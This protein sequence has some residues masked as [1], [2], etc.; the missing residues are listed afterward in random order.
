MINSTVNSVQH[1]YYNFETTN[2]SFIEM[3]NYLKNTGRERNKF[4]LAL[5]D[6]DLLGV[7]PRDPNL[8]RT[9]KAKVIREVIVNYWYF[10]REVVRIPVPGNA[11]GIRYGLHRGNLAANFLFTFNYN[12]FLELPRQHGKTTVALIR[13]L[14]LYNFGATFTEMMFINKK[15]EDTKRA[16][17]DV[18]KYRD[19]LPEYLQFKEVRERDGSIARTKNN[20]T[21][22]ENPVNHNKIRT[23]PG[24]RTK[25]LAN[26][27]GRGCT[28]AVQYYD[29]FGWILYNKEIYQAAV[30]AFSTASKNA[31]RNKS[32]FGILIT[33]TPGDMTTNEG[34]F[35]KE[36]RDNATPWDESFYD[37]DFAQLEEIRM[38]NSSSTFFHV[39]YSYTQLGSGD[40]YFKDMVKQM[41]KDWNAIRR[42]VLLEW[43]TAN[44]NC[45]FDKDALEIIKGLCKTPI[46]TM[47]LGPMKQ[48]QFLVYKDIDLR[49]PPII[50][51]D[52][53]GGYQ[54]DSSTIT[55][56]DSRTTEVN[57]TFNCNY[58]TPNDL[59]R[60]IYEL[61]TAYMP[62]AIVNI[63]QNGGFGASVIGVLKKTSIRKNLYYEWK[64][65]VL[66]ERYAGDN[67][68]LVK[69]KQTV[70]VYG[71]N[72]NHNV[73][74]QLIDLLFERVELHKDKFNAAILHQEM[75]QMEVKSNG[76][77]EHSSNSHDDQVF[78]YLMALY[79]WYYGV[80]LRERYNIIK[81]NLT[82]DEDLE[83]EYLSLEDQFAMVVDLESIQVQPEEDTLHIQETIDTISSNKSMSYDEWLQSEKRKDD[84]AMIRIATDPRTKD[85]FIK[86]YGLD[87]KE[88][89]I[90]YNSGL[91][92]I[93][94]SVFNS[95]NSMI[96]L[97][98]EKN[99]EYDPL[100]GNMADMFRSIK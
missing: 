7:D 32:P 49:Y 91:K 12:I 52:V 65:R 28:T 93:D 1:I 69:H 29:E 79:V 70:K 19:A 35:A 25:Q 85:M 56:I 71:L 50:G 16:L 94:N 67:Q 81:T 98:D 68:N 46:R 13:Y 17:E 95:F 89:D 58:I 99:K 82:T 3:H 14:W 74:K 63:E 24:A 42:E 38:S 72:N 57:A 83:D 36:I 22:A 4:F 90:D 54:K 47:M 33:T 61:V 30:P 62:N 87:E 27:L 9:M 31:A 59:A 76:K 37:M 92:T 48:F 80:N 60:V 41:N 10:L 26:N 73:R 43:T 84:E 97:D 23:A 86:T 51:V 6:P 39:R 66:E 20:A 88:F 78:S 34:I 77:I 75:E 53:A 44:M 8:S 11:V 100:Q 2:M 64:D 18:R 40:E 96:F 15:Q 21:F 55:I 45:P 5:C